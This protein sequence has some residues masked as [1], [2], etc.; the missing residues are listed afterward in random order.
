MLLAPDVCRLLAFLGAGETRRKRA[1]GVGGAVGGVQGSGV[2]GCRG[3]PSVRRLLVV[4]RGW[5]CGGDPAA[6][7]G[8][9]S[10]VFNQ[11][12]TTFLVVAMV[13]RL[14]VFFL[15]SYWQSRRCWRLFRS[16]WAWA[17]L[18]GLR[19]GFGGWLLPDQ[20]RE[21][22]AEKGPVLPRIGGRVFPHILPT[23]PWTFGGGGKQAGCL[24][25]IRV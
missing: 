12:L 24:S 11:P 23:T 18:G 5:L 4:F 22:V 3:W 2:M 1:A 16:P 7:C 6:I 13:W 14:A 9:N 15:C 8:G 19:G 17:V 20:S 25:A 10:A 21:G